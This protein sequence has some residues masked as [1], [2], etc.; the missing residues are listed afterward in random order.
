MFRTDP[1]PNRAQLG[2]AEAVLSAFNFLT[3]EYGFHLVKADATFVRYESPHVFV[4]VYHGRASYELG[5]E[6][7]RLIDMAGQ[8]EH[9]FSLAMVIELMGAQIET[10]YTLLQ[11]SS[12]ERVKKYVPKLADLVKKYAA[13]ALK[14]DSNTFK[15]L[16]ET[17]SRMSDEIHKDMKLKDTRED[18]EKAWRE[19]NYSKLASLY[20][21]ISEDLTPAESK[22]LDYAK[23]HS[24]L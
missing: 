19:K 14:N 16:A 15:L 5:F 4:N 24:P 6:I 10:G 23:K 3:K 22:K 2:F 21:S 8:G 18:A 9:P 13:S 20:E 17:R 1:G 11:A 7:G 12:P